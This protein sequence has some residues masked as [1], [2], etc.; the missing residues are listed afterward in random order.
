[1]IFFIT[2]IIKCS[3]NFCH[4]QSYVGVFL[5][6]EGLDCMKKLFYDMTTRKPE[7]MLCQKSKN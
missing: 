5:G 6:F 2:G 3:F 1:M 7:G 4:Q